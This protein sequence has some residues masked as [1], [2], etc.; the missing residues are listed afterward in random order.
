MS[1]A[2]EKKAMEI[3]DKTL[4]KEI[5][6]DT[7]V[8]RFLTSLGLGVAR[9]GELVEKIVGEDVSLAKARLAGKSLS[10]KDLDVLSPTIS[11]F[12]RLGENLVSTPEE[13]AL[14][15]EV[16]RRD[17]EKGLKDIEEKTGL[18]FNP[19]QTSFLESQADLY[20]SIKTYLEKPLATTA[21]VG[22]GIGSK[23]RADPAG[24]LGEIIGPSVVLGGLK[25]GTSI[26]KSA[27]G[28][29]S[30]GLT[31]LQKIAQV[32]DPKFFR[33]SKNF[34]DSID[35]ASRIG[36]SRLE[37]GTRKFL[38]VGDKTDDAL[39][40]ASKKIN[41]VVKQNIDDLA[42]M[43]SKGIDFDTKNY[44][45]RLKKE[46]LSEKP[47]VSSSKELATPN[48]RVVSPDKGIKLK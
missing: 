11:G 45:A 34:V 18:K 35:D 13:Y 3:R 31:E 5:G 36:Y 39:A 8:T 6:S 4:L 15:K 27:L 32:S 41:K 33:S 29:Q 19:Q 20:S 38:S 14:S 1:P 7:S 48:L 24:E 12:R 9:S 2:F 25:A 23:I 26:V 22:V 16:T 47:P 42:K 10:E 17:L 43:K 37:A 44:L 28:I 40:V 30:K 46:I 21:F